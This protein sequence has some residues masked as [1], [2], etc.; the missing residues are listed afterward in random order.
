MGCAL[1]KL[2]VET[3][4]QVTNL[5]TERGLGAASAFGA[6]AET[7]LIEH[8]DEAFDL[9]KIHIGRPGIY[10]RKTDPVY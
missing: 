6:L 8:G 3:Q 1:E 9:T 4:L 2:Q 7:A 5:L 10:I